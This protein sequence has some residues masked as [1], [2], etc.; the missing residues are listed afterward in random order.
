MLSAAI[1]NMPKLLAR[2]RARANENR[3][4]EAEKGMPNHPFFLIHTAILF[5]I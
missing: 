5:Q 4:Q 1:M 2:G 3:Y